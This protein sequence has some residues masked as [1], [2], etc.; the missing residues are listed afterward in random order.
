V[1][2]LVDRLELP[3]PGDRHVLAAAIAGGARTIVTAN[4]RHFPSVSLRQHRVA[5][6][7]PDRFLQDLCDADPDVV[8]ASLRDQARRYRR[9]PMSMD[10]LLARLGRGGT[11]MFAKR[12]MNFPEFPGSGES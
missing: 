9:P 12:M 3:D 4:L 1:G 11:P 8:L 2:G 6:I 10:D 7:S 5:A